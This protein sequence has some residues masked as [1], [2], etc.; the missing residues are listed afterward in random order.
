MIDHEHHYDDASLNVLLF[1]DEQSDEYRGCASHVESCPHCQER[2]TRLA[3]EDPMWSEAGEYLNETL[4]GVHGSESTG[5][6][7]PAAVQRQ[8]DCLSPA[9]HP[10]MLG[11]L[12]RY[13]IERVI[14]TGGMGIVLKGFDTEL[15]RP[16]AVK[17]LASHLAHSGAAR[18]RF[19]RE[20]RAAAAIVHEHVVSI[21]NVETDGETPFLVMQFVAGESLQARVDREGPLDAIEILRIG[22]QAAAGLA[23]AHEQGVVHR[24]IKPANILLEED[25]ERTLLTDFGLARTVDDA[26]L[27]HTGIVAGTPHYMSP[28]QAS[29]EVVDHRTDLFSLG[30]VLYFMATGRPPFRADKAMGVLNRICNDRHRP[31]WEVNPEVPDGLSETIDRLLEKRPGRRFA[32][33]SQV[34]QALLRSLERVQRGGPSRTVRLRRSFRRHRLWLIPTTMAVLGGLAALLAVRPIVKEPFPTPAAPI[35][36]RS[37]DSANDTVRFET[38]EYSATFDDVRRRLEQLEATGRST[39]LHVP[40]SDWDGE[41]QSIHAALERLSDNPGTDPAAS[42]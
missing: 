15:N 20:S 21:H 12:G 2:L 7:Q 42:E 24:D 30:A 31:V 1:G 39:Y 9:S 19:A 8:L 40:G 23:A 38:S 34:R 35:V 17:L 11:R 27:T 13:E 25:V 4:D 29:G 3:A 22:A 16:V 18:Q 14:G 32:D 41:M 28:E 36:E 33:A 37:T 10:E 26:S 5:T 6:Q